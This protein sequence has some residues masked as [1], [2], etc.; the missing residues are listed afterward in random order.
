V[1]NK[2]RK[3][4]PGRWRTRQLDELDWAIIRELINDPAVTDKELGERLGIAKRTAW[5]RRNNPRLQL[6]IRELSRDMIERTR[7]L[8]KKAISRA[9]RILEIGEDKD[10]KTIAAKIINGLPEIAA[11]VLQPQHDNTDEPTEDEIRALQE[12]QAEVAGRKAALKE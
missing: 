7:E 2:K 12:Y 3:N 4:S 1:D 9:E 10:A 8:M 6:E 5:L 11:G